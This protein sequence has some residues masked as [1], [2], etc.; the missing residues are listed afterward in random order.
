MAPNLTPAGRSILLSWLEP[1]SPGGKPGQGEMALRYSAFDGEKWSA[2]RTVLSSPKIFANWAD[3][4]AIAVARGGSLLAGWPEKSGGG[5]Y[6]YFLQ[7]ARAPS[8]G[9]PWRRLGP[10]H[11]DRTPTEHGFVSF[12]PEDDAIRA[13]WLDGRDM[14]GES[15]SMSLRTALVGERPER[16]ELLDAKVCDCCQ[17]SAAV[18][19]EGPL[20]VYRDRS[21]GE[22]RDMSIVRRAGG[23]WT[24]PRPVARDGWKIAGCPVNGPA[25]AASGRRVAVAW[26]TVAQEKPRVVL[27]ISSDAGATFGE[28]VGIDDDGPAGR[29]DVT[30]DSNGD[31]I[32]CWVAAAGKDAAIRLRRVRPHGPAGA[33]VTVA[34][35]SLARSSGFPRIERIGSTLL[36]VWVEA[37]EPFRLHAAT[38][39]LSAVPL[40]AR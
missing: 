38:L 27:A 24:A 2:P 32:V 15:G 11:E 22:V 10:A 14:K 25:A 39:P 26:F 19:S 23:K 18:T 36:V 1:L 30:L 13:F 33:P 40:P 3:F 9:G 35:T 34:P 6:D 7:L 28:P 8:S 31:A 4:P 21:D 5:T 12:V 29:V 16:S 37:S 17:T 20:V